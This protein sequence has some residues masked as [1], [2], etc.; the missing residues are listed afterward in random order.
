MLMDGQLSHRGVI[1][2]DSKSLLDKIL[3][4][5]GDNLSNITAKPINALTPGWDLLI[6]I[7]KGLHQLP[8][9]S[10]TH[11]K[12]HRDDN[13]AYISLSLLAQ[14]IVDTDKIA[15]T[16]QDAHGQPN[17]FVLMLPKT[18]VHL[19]HQSGT[20]TSI[21]K[22]PSS[23]RQSSCKIPMVGAHHGYDKLDGA[24]QSA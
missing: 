8:G 15:G 13:K 7:Q 17:S 21:G 2:T 1:G 24:R 11:V 23:P 9:V 14:L 22:W 4:P 3:P 16:Y 19:I 12:G 18:G 6:E 20:I 5:L 10:L